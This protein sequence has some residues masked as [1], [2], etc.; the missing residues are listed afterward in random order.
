MYP[1]DVVLSSVSK[2]A[3][4]V[5]RIRAR[6]SARADRL[7]DDPLAAVLAGALG[8]EPQADVEPSPQ[9]RAIAFQVIVRTR[10]YDD[11]L[12]AAADAGIRQ[13][14]VLA[15]GLDARAFRLPWPDGTRLF[16]L[17][18]LPMVDAKEQVLRGTDATPRCDRVVVG[19][20]LAGE[21]LSVLTAAGWDPAQPTA[22]LAEGLLVYLDAPVAQAVLEQ[23][24]RASLPGS[25]LAFERSST[26]S[27]ARL[28][29]ADT[30]AVTQLWR[31]G[32][33]DKPEGWLA[34]RGWD[35]TVD[36]LGEVAASYGRPIARETAAGFITA[37][38]P[39]H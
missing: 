37:R 25:R 12:L 11:Y 38:R 36:N 19:V 6:E 28:S 35:V 15:A 8:E 21:W 14:V 24:T 17:D 4:G 20:D 2:T 7:F 9:R 34:E 5:A 33:G 22:W 27:A 10:Y 26:T 31:G 16:E 18:L 32:L 39:P 30:Q 1:V 23:V 29:T 13:L 3:V